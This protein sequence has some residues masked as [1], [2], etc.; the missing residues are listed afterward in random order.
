MSLFLILSAYVN[1]LKP[2][3]SINAGRSDTAVLTLATSSIRRALRL[4]VPVLV[5]TVLNW[6]LTQLGAF[7]K[8]SYVANSW[9]NGTA[10]RGSGSIVHAIFDLLVNCWTTW[11]DATNAYDR[12]LW[13]MKWFLMGS[14]TLYAT[15]IVTA[16]VRTATRR[17]ILVLLFICSWM[18]RDDLVGMPTFGGILICD[19]ASSTGLQSFAGRQSVVKSLLTSILF[20]VGLY[21]LSFPSFA[22]HWSPWYRWM[23]P[24][25][26]FP[27]NA[28]IFNYSC[29]LGVFFILFSIS[30]SPLLQG[31]FSHK[32]LLWVG[33]R[34]L[35]IYLVHGPILRS[36]FCWVAYAFISPQVIERVNDEGYIV[37]ETV[38]LGPPTPGR[39][40]LGLTVFVICT[41]GAATV[42][43]SKVDPWCGRIVKAFEQM[44]A[45]IKQV[46]RPSSAGTEPRSESPKRSD[47]SCV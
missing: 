5:V 2:I 39:L 47:D 22:W 42:W 46:D 36:V 34:S 7:S 27:P 29:H 15:L 9:L 17:T 41:I 40:V 43:H 18:K 26:L 4:V 45:G 3:A 12:N 35:P 31:I 20:I 25:S 16:H 6:T 44:C 33:T 21:F 11:S 13:C 10:P 1:A 30:L 37:L 14:L 32:L 23:L 19:L 38:L 8:A 28:T 24:L